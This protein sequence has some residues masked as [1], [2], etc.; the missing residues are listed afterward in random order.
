MDRLG[1]IAGH[2]KVS[3]LLVERMNLLKC[4][5]VSNE[6][7]ALVQVTIEGAVGILTLNSPKTLNAISRSMMFAIIE[8]Q[9]QLEVDPNVKV[10][11]LNSSSPKVFCAGGDVKGFEDITYASKMLYD[12]SK[13]GSIMLETLRKPMIASVNRMAFGGGFELVLASDCVVC[14]EEAVFCQP[15]IT[16]GIFPGL[17]GTLVSKT[18]G[19]QRAMEMVLSGKRIPA[20][21]MQEWGIV[22]HIVKKEE[23]KEATMK[24]ANDIA[25][26]SRTSLI[27]A[28]S[29]VKFSYENDSETSRMFER[30]VLSSIDNSLPGPKEGVN[31]FITK[32]KPN[33]EGI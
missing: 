13:Q 2:Q 14:D 26:F 25:K 7:P 5:N 12:Y 28:K 30:R 11:V 1:K 10:V 33:F 32:R 6:N 19:K 16:L 31:A 4:E 8:A 9:K 17:G 15:E 20:K 24:L 22:N 18:I 29:S 21:K 3:K 27:V 23:L